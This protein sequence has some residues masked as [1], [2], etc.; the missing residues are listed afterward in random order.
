MAIQI[1]TLQESSLHAALKDWYAQP[2]DD[3]EVQ[4]RGYWVDIVRG[5][6]ADVPE[7]LIEIQTGNFAAMKRKLVC[8]LDAYTVRVVYP[9]VAEKYIVRIASKA[10]QVERLSRRK[11]SKRGHLVDL[12]AE[13]VRIPQLVCSPNFSL[14]V[15]FVRIEEFWLDDGKGSWRRKGVSIFDRKLMDVLQRRVFSAP[16]DYLSLLPSDLPQPFTVKDLAACL[17]RP[18][19]LAGRMA[20]ALR[21]M[22]CLQVAG[23]RGNAFQY[24][25]A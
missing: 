2:G 10:G 25:K 7:I 23:K 20:Y 22:G 18:R 5:A 6:T 19:W 17:G 8:L 21:E 14:E 11:S 3:F 16:Q 4:R 12:F 1:G 15:L 9:L 13:L 24:V